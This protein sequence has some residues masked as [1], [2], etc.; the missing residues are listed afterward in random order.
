MT[1]LVLM[2]LSDNSEYYSS[3][4]DLLLVKV[5]NFLPNMNHR[6]YYALLFL[7][8]QIISMSPT[9][10]HFPITNLS[11]HSPWLLT[12]PTDAYERAR[13]ETRHI[14][15]DQERSVEQGYTNT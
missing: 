3:H 4:D 1:T 8:F 13:R 14:F 12:N 2:K 15:T 6:K 11:L 7:F 9:F 10:S 5:W